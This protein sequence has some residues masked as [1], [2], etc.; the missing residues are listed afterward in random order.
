MRFGSCLYYN[1]AIE[2][3]LDRARFYYVMACSAILKITAIDIVRASCCKSMAVKA[4]N[5]FYLKLLEMVG[6]S[7]LREM[8]L[9]DSVST[10][11]QVAL[12]KPEFFQDA[13]SSTGRPR[14]NRRCVQRLGVAA[15]LQ[16]TDY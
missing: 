16:N 15:G 13:S 5:K 9:I 1:R 11:R 14:R 2:S 4:D 12:L 6:L 10:T 8:A 3:D 7:S